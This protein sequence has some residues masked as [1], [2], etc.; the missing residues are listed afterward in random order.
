MDGDRLVVGEANACIRKGFALFSNEFQTSQ[1]IPRIF[2]PFFK[3]GSA[4]ALG[5]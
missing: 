4:L 3:A 5:R 1:D 2:I